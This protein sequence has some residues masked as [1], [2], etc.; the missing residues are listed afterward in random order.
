MIIATPIIVG[1]AITVATP[2]G[3][4]GYF[5]MFLCAGGKKAPGSHPE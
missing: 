2:N 5:A 1:Y 3:G 4:A